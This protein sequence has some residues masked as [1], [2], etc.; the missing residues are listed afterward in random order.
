MNL[1]TLNKPLIVISL[2]KLTLETEKKS[3]IDTNINLNQFLHSS[4]NQIINLQRYY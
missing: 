3:L 1:Y 4:S 2:E